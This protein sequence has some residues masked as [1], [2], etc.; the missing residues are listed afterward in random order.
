M[1]VPVKNLVETVDLTAEDVLLPMLECVVNSV[2]SL[3]KSPLPTNE[4]KIQVQVTRGDLPEKL[5]FDNIKTIL[6]YKVIDNGIGFNTSNYKSFQTPFSQVNKDFGCKGI[7]RFTVLAAYKDFVVESNYEENATWHNRKFKFSTEN[8]LEIIEFGNSEIQQ[9]KT[10][11]DIENCTNHILIEK[12]ALS[13]LQISESIMQH[14]FIYYLNNS[15]PRIE[16]IDLENNE[17]EVINELFEKVSKEKERDFPLKGEDFKF[18]IT[19]TLKEGNR[20]NNYLYYCANNRTVG[21]PKNIKN[22]NSIFSYPI[23]IDNEYYFFDIYVVSD[24]LNRKVFKTRNGFNIPKERENLLFNDDNTVTFQDIE[25][26]ISSILENEYDSFV[27]TAKEKNIENVKSYILHKAPRFNSFLKNPDILNSIPPNLSEDKLEEHL[28]RISFNARRNVENNI[29]KFIKTKEVNEG[30]IGQIINDIKAK[31]A[32]DIDSLADY[33]MRR[34]AIINLFDKFLDA[35][36]NGDYKLEEDVHNLIFPLGLTNND[37]DYENHNLWILDERFISYKFIASDK[38]IT[39]FSQMKSRKE[40]D[41]IL[42][43]NPQMFNNPISFGD[44]A[45]GEVNAMVIFEFKRPGDVAHQKN[46][47]DYRWEFSELVEPYFEEFIYQPIKKNYKG[48][49]V[50][51]KETTPKFG[52]IILDVI[53][54][55]LAKYNKNKGWKVTPFGTYFK[56]EAELNLHLE[57]MTFRQLLEASKQRHNPF[58]DKLF[59]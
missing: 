52:Y 3:Q 54:E 27:K 31:T 12:S 59:T 2:I 28:Y 18:Y 43:D 40:T 23:Q 22:I 55:P 19:K 41:L 9:W 35:D 30:A 42:I 7:G 33:M 39:S 47:T 8:E 36:E 21:N 37:L 1:E 11:V 53:P 16:V 58:F 14:C 4:K 25:E 32:Y 15:L 6:G 44:K 56:I 48:N 38:S 5:N 29:E 10:I 46:K 17:V 51:L 50:I 49:Q 57:V 45:S 24:F 13:L 34:K 26:Q 20:K